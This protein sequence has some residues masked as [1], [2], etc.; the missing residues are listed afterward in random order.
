MQNKN[1]MQLEQK[2]LI[3]DNELNNLVIKGKMSEALDK[4]YCDNVSIQEND[5][6]PTIG[7]AANLAREKTFFSKVECF[8][9][10]EV[11][12]SGV[13]GQTTF[14]TWYVDFVHKELGRLEFTQVAVRT[15]SDHRVAKEVFY[16]GMK[17]DFLSQS[18][19]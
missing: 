11:L 2:L 17:T 10:T 12:A 7:K 9:T 1:I 4:F 14:S 19:K 5:K 13:G 6:A 15:W 16:Y 18:G 8:N 3:L